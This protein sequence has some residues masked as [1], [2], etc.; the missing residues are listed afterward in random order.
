MADLDKVVELEVA[1]DQ[2]VV[3]P[4]DQAVVALVEMEQQILVE[5]VLVVDKQVEQ[6]EM[7]AL[8]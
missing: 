7:V 3:A 8:V 4:E 6:V 5:V 1:E 2:A